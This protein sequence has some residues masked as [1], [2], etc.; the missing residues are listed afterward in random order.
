MIFEKQ[1]RNIK[2]VF[3]FS[4][5]LLSETSHSKMWARYYQKS[6]LFFVKVPVIL[7]QF[8]ENLNFLD[9]FSINTKI[10]NFMKIRPMQAEL[11]H[12]YRHDEANSRF[13]QFCE[14][15]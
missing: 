6:I 10:L 2:C 11:F 4:L 14:R 5:Q 7:V 1:L 8:N 15:A 9:R 13:S 12:V 3:R